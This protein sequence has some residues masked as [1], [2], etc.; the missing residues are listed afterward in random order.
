MLVLV[1]MSTIA[2]ESWAQ[3]AIE[4]RAA[5]LEQAMALISDPDPMVRLAGMEEILKSG[6]GLKI[7]LATTTA[8]QSDDTTMKGLAMRGFIVNQ[9]QIDFDIT[10]PEKMEAEYQK[11]GGDLEK[12]EAFLDKYAE[13]GGKSNY[14]NSLVRSIHG[15]GR[16]TSLY[17]KLDDDWL[18]GMASVQAEGEARYSG[19]ARFNG[20]LLHFSIGDTYVGGDRNQALSNCIFKLNAPDK[21]MITGQMKC[22]AFTYLLGA[23]VR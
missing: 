12:V 2:A 7:S 5:D 21:G 22:G 16:V 17:F 15:G 4:A 20:D 23:P 8:M 6:D 9:G 14:G 3:S 1:A 18:G 11:A 19:A 10:F 13:A